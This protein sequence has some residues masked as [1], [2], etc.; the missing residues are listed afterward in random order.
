M[1]SEKPVHSVICRR[2]PEERAATSIR[3]LWPPMR[4]PELLLTFFLKGALTPWVTQHGRA[5][6]R[7]GGSGQ[8][9]GDSSVAP[10]REWRRCVPAPCLSPLDQQF[11]TLNTGWAPLGGIKICGRP[12]FTHRGSDRGRAQALHF[13]QPSL[14]DCSG[15]LGW[16][17]AELDRRLPAC[18]ACHHSSLRSGHHLQEV[19]PDNP[20]SHH[21]PI[22]TPYSLPTQCEQLS[23]T[24][25][26]SLDS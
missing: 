16:R 22:A 13:P 17:S 21:L 4:R 6:G 19:L 12:G 5:A 8:G 25:M 10:W 23:K 18:S 1:S 15:Q 20:P 14:G 26:R 24:V 2:G 3:P 7:A 9:V 11:S